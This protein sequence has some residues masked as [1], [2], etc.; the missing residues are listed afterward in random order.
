MEL[1]LLGFDQRLHVKQFGAAT[2]DEERRRTY[3]LR[4]EIEWPMS[5]DRRVWPSIFGLY[6]DASAKRSISFLAAE[7]DPEMWNYLDLWANLSEMQ[8][9]YARHGAGESIAVVPVA[10]GV[11]L[12]GLNPQEA[13]WP[14]SDTPLP[15]SAKLIGFDVADFSLT[16][17]VSN[18]GYKEQAAEVLRP[19]WRDRINDH[20]LIVTVEDAFEFK[21]VSDQRVRE[22][23]P[24]YVFAVYL[25]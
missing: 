6:Y 14:T 5:V 23:S 12:E 9:W 16:S 2:W 7:P 4:P 8:T 19:K 21:Q 25:L 24:F 3:L 10:I 15:S 11:F 17:A 22:H 18:C 13:F 20:G 1:N